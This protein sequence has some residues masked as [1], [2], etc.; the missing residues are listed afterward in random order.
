VRALTY[1]IGR[2]D[3]TPCLEVRGV[4]ADDDLQLLADAIDHLVDGGARSVIL[5]LAQAHLSAELAECLIRHACLRLPAA[6]VLV[7]DAAGL[8]A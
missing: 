3:G 8:T 4:A 5:S 6:R 1:R 7:D 2:R